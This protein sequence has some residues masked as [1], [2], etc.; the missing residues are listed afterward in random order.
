[1]LRKNFFTCA[2]VDSLG[3]RMTGSISAL[4]VAMINDYVLMVCVLPRM[5]E[6][7]TALEGI[8]GNPYPPQNYSSGDSD[9][10]DG[11]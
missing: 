11:C 1:M 8:D 10:C 9:Q 5:P 7:E 4:I 3:V 6:Y 2:Q